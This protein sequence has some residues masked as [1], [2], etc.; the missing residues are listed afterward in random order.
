MEAAGLARRFFFMQQAGRVSDAGKASH[1][2]IPLLATVTGK[3]ARSSGRRQ[4]GDAVS[5]ASAGGYPAV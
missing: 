5:G 1:R 3:I 4:A 2:D